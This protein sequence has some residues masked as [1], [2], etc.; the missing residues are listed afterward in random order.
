[1]K[2]SHKKWTTS[3]KDCEQ[4]AYWAKKQ[5]RMNLKSD[6][7]QIKPWWIITNLANHISQSNPHAYIPK[8]I[9][10]DFF[11]YF[12]ILFLKNPCCFPR[13][14]TWRERGKFWFSKIIISRKGYRTN[15]NT[16]EKERQTERDNKNR[17]TQSKNV[18]PAGLKLLVFCLCLCPPRKVITKMFSKR[19]G[20][21]SH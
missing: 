21:L 4:E 20:L 1:M 16:R 2:A 3:G 5:R 8:E 12:Y 7:R 15:R 17:D 10:I 19:K 11:R 9:T 13:R 18:F 14:I 6:P